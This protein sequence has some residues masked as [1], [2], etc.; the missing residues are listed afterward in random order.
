VLFAEIDAL[1]MNLLG[2]G[3]VRDFVSL[4]RLAEDDDS[5]KV[6]VFKS[7]DLTRVSE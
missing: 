5:L 6:A 1:Q 7:A 2:P 3:L 4:I